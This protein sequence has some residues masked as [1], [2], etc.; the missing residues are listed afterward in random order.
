MT[1]PYENKAKLGGIVLDAA[2]A[3]VHDD[4]DVDLQRLNAILACEAFVSALVDVGCMVTRI[5]TRAT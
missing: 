3:A 1:D 4:S 2:K 5:P